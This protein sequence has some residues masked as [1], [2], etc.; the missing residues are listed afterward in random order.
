MGMD[1]NTNQKM[2]SQVETSKEEISTKE[3]ESINTVFEK[4]QV[5]F[6]DYS[7]QRIKEE[8]NTIEWDWE[9]WI[10]KGYVTLIVGTS[11]IG[12]SF[13]VLRI[14]GCYTNGMKWPDGRNYDLE[15]GSVLWCEGEAGQVMNSMRA[16]QLGIN[17]SKIITPFKDPYTEFDI[18]NK[19]HRETLS[20]W[21]KMYEIKLIVIDSLSG[22]HK[23]DENSA[24]MNELIKN[25][26]E[27]A[28]NTNKPI[29]ITHHL[30]KAGKYDIYDNALDRIRGSS[31]IV[32]TAR[33]II[34]I[35]EINDNEPRK[36]MKVI[37]NNLGR[38]PEPVDFILED[39]NFT[40][41]QSAGK[42]IEE[43]QLENAKKYLREQLQN[44]P[45]DANQIISKARAS[46][47]KEKTLN[48]AKQRLAIKS[49]RN[50]GKNGKWQWGYFKNTSQ[51]IQHNFVG[52]LPIDL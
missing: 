52:D 12:K 26:A 33:V 49:R 15:K 4:K 46:G 18:S 25:F 48:I 40:F 14:C 10:A 31:T 8:S 7:W 34:N 21:A 2:L 51:E 41:S 16:Q 36:Q 30:R 29:L 44:G 28:R 50:G 43:S 19:D 9:K 37:K 11:G 24:E 39:G 5:T 13:L 20:Q 1:M 38:F 23:K 35:D 42:L 6:E 3:N 27:L 47:I 45:V 22:I 17:L 32:Q